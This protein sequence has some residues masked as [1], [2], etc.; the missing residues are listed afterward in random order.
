ML[1]HITHKHIMDYLESNNIFSN[2]QP[3]FRRG[4]SYLNSLMT[5]LNLGSQVDALFV[6]FLKA[7][8]TVV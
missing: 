2:C 5:L 7:F 3:G 8:D 4:L 6:D 1:E